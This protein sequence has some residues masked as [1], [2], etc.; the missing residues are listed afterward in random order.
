MKIWTL[1]ENTSGKE[2]FHAEHGLSLYIE[3]GEKRI[4]FDMGQTGKFAENAEKMDIDLSKVDMAVLSH[5]HYD[6]GGGLE[7][8]LQ[9]NSQANVYV[10]RHAFGE[11]RNGANDYIGLDPRFA[12]H[13]RLVKVG[14]RLSL[15]DGILLLSCNDREKYFP[16]DS[17]LLR[18]KQEDRLL[19][20][21]FLH[22]QYLVVEERGTRVC[23]SGC[24]HKGILNIAAWIP[25]DALIGGFHFVKMDPT[26]E[27]V[28]EAARVLS[29]RKTVYYTCHCTGK[30]QFAAMKN[31]MGSKLHYL[32][33]GDY[34]EIGEA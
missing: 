26:G 25:C 24:S 32:A 30:A 16:T 17:A 1:M 18:K 13:S 6:H 2:G 29:E 7:T 5:G 22:E 28:R 33:A 3:T 14:D 12:D 27:S 23:F 4:L 20:D 15:G 31:R 9:V 11:Y 8:F 34:L 21:D 10:S 19:P